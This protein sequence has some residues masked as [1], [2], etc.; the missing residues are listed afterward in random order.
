ME[1]LLLLLLLILPGSFY[2]Q[3]IEAIICNAVPAIGVSPKTQTTSI[4]IPELLSPFGNCKH[5]FAGKHELRIGPGTAMW[6]HAAFGTY[7][8]KQPI[9]ES[10]LSKTNH[11]LSTISK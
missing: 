11:Q 1:R 8:P 10:K 6:Y 7:F 9:T 3:T 4:D 2:G 5:L